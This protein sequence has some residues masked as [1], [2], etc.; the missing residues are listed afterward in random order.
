MGSF[1][2][3][4]WTI[5]WLQEESGE[6]RFQVTVE[7]IHP[8]HNKTAPIGIPVGLFRDRETGLDCCR[9]LIDFCF[10]EQARA[11]A[12]AAKQYLILRQL[13]PEFVEKTEKWRKST[14]RDGD[15]HQGKEDYE[16]S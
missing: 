14:D 8:I 12:N 9:A 6:Y 16:P 7:L 11:I 2:Y 13:M 15:A 5:V 3:G 4:D 10:E 1:K